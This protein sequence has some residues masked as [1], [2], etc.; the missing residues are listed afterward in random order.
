MINSKK[1]LVFNKSKNISQNDLGHD[2]V[3]N[4]W[5]VT[6]RYYANKRKISFDI[7]IFPCSF[8]YKARLSF[9]V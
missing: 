7:N 1:E 5:L 6:L 8:P 3:V 4:V 9:S 2:T